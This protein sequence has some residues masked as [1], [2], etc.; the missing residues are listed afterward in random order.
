MLSISQTGHHFN[1]LNWVPTTSGPLIN[2]AGSLSY[3]NPDLYSSQF[4]QSLFSSLVVKYKVNPP[5]ICL[6]L[7]SSQVEFSETLLDD[8][9]TDKI[10]LDW[11]NNL[12][13]DPEFNQRVDTYSYPL[14]AENRKLLNIHYSRKKRNAIIDA[15]KNS[16]YEIRFLSIGIFSAEQGARLW[17]NAK[18]LNSYL[19]W[20]IGGYHHNQVLFIRD[21]KMVSLFMFKR[22]ENTYSLHNFFGSRILTD[23]LFSQLETCLDYNLSNLNIPDKIFIYSGIGSASEINKYIQLNKDNVCHLNPLEKIKMNMERKSGLN[24]K[25]AES[26]AVFRGLDV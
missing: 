2:A 15:V 1:Y 23:E 10:F 19:I 22:I 25:F 14:T 13:Y 24:F 16:G 8:S 9:E 11:V 20:R 7:D 26:G 18:K 4:Y 5:V 6:S 21:M 3:E 12:N 17:F